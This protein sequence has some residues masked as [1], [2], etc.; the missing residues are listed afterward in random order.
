MAGQ[1]EER[2]GRARA[3]GAGGLE[4]MDELRRGRVRRQR[5]VDLEAAFSARSCHGLAEPLFEEGAPIAE[6]IAHERHARR[7]R[8]SAAL[9]RDAGFDRRA[10]RP[11]KID[12]G[13]RP[14]GAGRMPAHEGEREGRALEPFL[15]PRRKQ[16]DDA[17]RPSLSR[18][19]NRRDP[20]L[21]AERQQSF[22]LGLG[23]R[24]NLDLLADAV[25]PIEFG[26]DRA[27]LDVVGRGQD[28]TPS[29]ASPMRPP[30]L[31]R[32]PIINPRW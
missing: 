1:G 31:M 11:A 15:K 6:P 32:G 19:D 30:A 8:M 5:R 14:A 29:A 2:L 23:K 13:D 16:A 18:D 27:R 24:C 21:E 9:D 12:P 7:H 4:A 10:H 28:L 17:R 26:G 3:I 20:L 22:R 25:Q